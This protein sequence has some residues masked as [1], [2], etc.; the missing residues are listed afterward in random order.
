[1]SLLLVLPILKTTAVTNINAYSWQTMSFRT[2]KKPS[3]TRCVDSTKKRGVSVWWRPSQ[4]H[5]WSPPMWG[6]RRWAYLGCHW[7]ASDGMGWSRRPPWSAENVMWVVKQRQ[8]WWVQKYRSL[9]YIF[10]RRIWNSN[11]CFRTHI[12]LVH[13]LKPSG[14]F[15]NSCENLTC[16]KQ[17]LNWL[18][19]STLS[20]SINKQG[21]NF[22]VPFGSALYI[23]ISL[24]SGL[25][26]EETMTEIPSIIHW[27]AAA[28]C[29]ALLLHG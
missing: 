7:S 10:Y 21:V 15:S 16:H 28:E 22:S 9:W 19:S 17:D 18:S 4:P 29:W 20:L 26:G 1:M 3:H 24:P 27:D 23:S 8:K 6:G 2:K 14:I 13:T 11:Q 12:K 25:V 5:R